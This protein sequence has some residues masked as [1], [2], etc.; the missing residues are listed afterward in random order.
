MPRRA[1]LSAVAAALST[2]AL[3]TAALAAALSATAHSATALFTAV[4]TVQPACGISVPCERLHVFWSARGRV[5]RPRVFPDVCRGAHHQR[6]AL[7]A[8]VDCSGRP[9]LDGTLELCR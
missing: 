5:A 6:I 2:T 4:A 8:R 9:L 1:A 3:S 7:C